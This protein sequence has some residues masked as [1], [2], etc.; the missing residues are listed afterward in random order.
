MT[1]VVGLCSLEGCFPF[2]GVSKGYYRKSC[3][4]DPY[5]RKELPSV[6][7]AKS[8][9]S[10]G[11]IKQLSRYQFKEGRKTGSRKQKAKVREDKNF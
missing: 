3:S 7:R 2:K 1:V 10:K 4:E 5:F 11:I 9:F 6:K 8:G